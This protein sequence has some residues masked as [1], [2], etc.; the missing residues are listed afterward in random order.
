MLLLINCSVGGGGGG[1]MMRGSNNNNVGYAIT[2]GGGGGGEDPCAVTRW[3]RWGS[4]SRSCGQGL[5][6][7]IREYVNPQLASTYSCGIKLYEDGPCEGSNG[8]N[9]NEQEQVG[10][11]QLKRLLLLLGWLLTHRL[12]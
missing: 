12:H 10:K 2:S 9:C 3:N 11:Q 7:R 6:R 8:P 5:R 4:C 1:G